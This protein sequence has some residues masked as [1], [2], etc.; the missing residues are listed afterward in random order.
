MDDPG[1]KTAM[2]KLK[3][4]IVHMG[5]AEFQNYWD[6][7]TARLVAIVQYIGKVQ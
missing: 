2:E 5:P 4:P 1:F 3:T 7:E 6:K